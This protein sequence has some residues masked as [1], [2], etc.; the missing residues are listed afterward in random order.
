MR[1]RI[2]LIGFIAIIM[3]IG[4]QVTV[5]A[6][7]GKTDSFFKLFGS[8][9]YHM[10]ARMTDGG[11]TISEMES[12][13]KGG[14]MATAVT[15]QGESSR[16]IFKDNKMYMIMDAAKTVMI[17]PAMNAS[18][19]GGVETAGMKLT[20]SGTAVFGGKSLP[21]EEYRDPQGN[22]AQYFLDGTK[23]AGIR[24]IANGGETTDLVILVLDQNVPNNVFDIPNG[25]QVQDMSS[26]GQ[27]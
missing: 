25:Y 27:F 26:F 15:A 5:F 23:L 9:T 4:S 3:I 24:N 6:Q 19:S 11:G 14:M 22:R 2:K 18:Q 16:M 13:M 12:F 7:T 17:L 1:N 21:Y 8:G 10:K 20:G